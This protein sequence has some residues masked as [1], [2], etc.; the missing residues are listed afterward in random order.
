MNQS[1]A[2]VLVA[3]TLGAVAMPGVARRLSIP[4]AVAEIVYGLIIGRSGLQLG[5]EFSLSFIE[6]LG[7][8]GFAF[9]MFLAGLELNLRAATQRGWSMPLLA[10]VLASLSLVLG[11][12]ISEQLGWGIWMG[13][14]MGATSV[15]LLLAVVREMRLSGTYLGS[16]MVLFAAVG[17]T[18][19]IV[20]L[21][22]VEVAHGAHSAA[23]WVYGVLRL[24][25]LTLIV[26]ATGALFRTLLWWFP[27]PFARLVALDDPSEIG[28]RVGFGLMFGFVG[29]SVLLGIEPFLGAFIAGAV[30]AF[31]LQDKGALEHKLTSMAYG[32]FVPVF[33]IDVGMRLDLSLTLVL[34]NG[35]TI[36]SIAAF[37][38]IVKFGPSLLLVLRGLRFVEVFATCCLLAAPLTLFIAIVDLGARVG[39]LTEEFEGIAITAGITASLLYPSFARFLLK[40][41][42]GGPVD[43]DEDEEE[44]TDA[45]V[46]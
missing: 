45:L 36:L 37:M 15:P 44:V 43:E 38:L 31:V 2:L 28:V 8:L 4:V 16:L 33:F 10:S 26:L 6:F 11:V 27:R 19:S 3:I 32:F 29:I 20:A 46:W 34:D 14:A 13:L 18:M 39:A 1:A 42:G 24:V 5:G 35:T 25:S 7:D 17:E 41:V 9:F 30:L 21:S 12:L 40:S 22:L 23:D